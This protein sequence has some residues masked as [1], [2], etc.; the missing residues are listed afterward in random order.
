MGTRRERRMVGAF[1]F[2]ISP[3][4]IRAPQ[5]PSHL[6]DPHKRPLAFPQ[7]N[8]NCSVL[9]KVYALA[10]RLFRNSARARVLDKKEKVGNEGKFSRARIGYLVL[11]LRCDFSRRK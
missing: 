4:E 11:K 6:G 1:L 8:V 5:L 9:I 7:K 2:T 10:F 3:D